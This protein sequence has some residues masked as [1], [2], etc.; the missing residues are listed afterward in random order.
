MLNEG[1]CEKIFKWWENKYNY[2]TY[3]L[4]DMKRKCINAT[5]FK[6]FDTLFLGMSSK[7]IFVNFYS[8]AIE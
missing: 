5:M 4:K 8:L 6:T 1:D 2:F 3:I 7:Q